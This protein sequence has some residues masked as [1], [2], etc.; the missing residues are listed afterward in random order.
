MRAAVYQGIEDIRIKEVPMPECGDGDIVIRVEAAGICGSDVRIY[1]SG[2]REVQPPQIIGHE[3]AGTIIAVGKGVTGYREADRINLTTEVS[4]QH[5]RYCR[6]G[7][8]N[9]CADRKAL[10]LYYAGGFAQYMLVPAAAVQGGN[11]VKLPDSLPF[12]EAALI[13][14]VTCGLNAQSYLQIGPADRVAILGA[15]AMGCVLLALAKLCG[16]T[17]TILI[18]ARSQSRLAL[19]RRI[20][21]DHYLSAAEQDPVEA[22]RALTGDA[23]ADVVIVAANA[24]TAA[25]Q[26]VRMAGLQG[27]V[28]L[29]AGFPADA[30]QISL[31]GNRIHY[32]EISIFG[33]FSSQRQHA[34]TAAALLASGKLDGSALITHRL[35]LDEVVRGIQMKRA[36]DSLKAV[37]LPWS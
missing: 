28:C 32:G 4:C 33:A 6:R 23:G 20:G 7:R 36:G 37:V 17:Q 11:V 1:Y 27:R 21:A 3:I 16:A 30:A 15:G 8:P 19:A 14:P 13:E 9:L 5:C 2:H 12:P 34:D 18:N 22:V 29:F 26:A 31:D 10:G 25:E 35:S 24:P